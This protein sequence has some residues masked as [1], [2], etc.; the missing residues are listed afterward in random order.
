MKSPSGS[1]GVSSNPEE[2]V[3]IL[4]ITDVE[5]NHFSLCSILQQPSWQ[6]RHIRLCREAR[7]ILNSH[8]VSVVL[9]EA[10]LADGDWKVLLQETRRLAE[11]PPLVVASRVADE[12][13]W[14]EVLN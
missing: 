4:H 11:P 9:S 6:L 2:P 5:V 3:L 7:N 14:S 1:L 12:R 8:P 13:L 10:V